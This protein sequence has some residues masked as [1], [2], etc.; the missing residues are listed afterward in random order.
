MNIIKNITLEELGTKED[1]WFKEQYYAIVN[2][3]RKKQQTASVYATSYYRTNRER[4]LKKR[5][6]QHKAKVGVQPKV[7]GRPR[8]YAIQQ[9]PLQDLK[10]DRSEY[11]IDLVISN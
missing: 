7:R 1:G 5:Q 10:T 2:D 4:I 11:E 9:L 6:E 8:K 3:M